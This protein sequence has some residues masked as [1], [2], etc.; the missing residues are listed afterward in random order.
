MNFLQSVLL[1]ILQGIAEFLP[2]SS[3]GHL[4]LARHL[5]QIDEKIVIP[6]IYDILLHVAT[7][8]AVIIVFR[9][10][11][12]NIIVSIIRAIQKKNNEQD[13]ENL[14]LFYLVIIATA[15]T[16][17]IGLGVKKFLDAYPLNYKAIASLSIVTGIILI[18]S[19]FFKGSKGY[20]ELNTKHGLITGIA[21][22]IGVFP[23]ISRSGITITASIASGI[24]REKA[25]EFSFLISI[26]AILGALIL[27]IKDLEIINVDPMVIVSGMAAAFITG[28]ASLILLLKIIK[29]GKFYYFSFY[30]IPMGLTFLIFL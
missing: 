29:S 11:I 27:D 2:I 19:K 1:G 13:K 4:E 15:A 16:L 9:K 5:M 12:K 3:S 22:G 26:P 21:Q 18:A 6:M 23:G 25:G 8:A 10:R 28:L 14:R 24:N 20:L 7:L 17:V 30:L